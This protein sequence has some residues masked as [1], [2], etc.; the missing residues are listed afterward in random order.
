MRPAFV[1]TD[2][3]QGKMTKMYYI[4]P[5]FKRTFSSLFKSAAHQKLGTHAVDIGGIPY[6]PMPVDS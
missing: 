4:T 6:H 2:Y 3:P 1:Y 5:F